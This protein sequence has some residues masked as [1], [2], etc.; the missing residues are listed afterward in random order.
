MGIKPKHQF[1]LVFEALIPPS[2]PDTMY[3]G[4][5]RHNDTQTL[6]C[7]NEKYHNLYL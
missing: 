4:S 5:N 6:K 7:H 3:R 1:A 2:D